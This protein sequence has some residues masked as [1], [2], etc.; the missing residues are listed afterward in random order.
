MTPAAGSATR[1][2][3]GATLGGRSVA[4]AAARVAAASL[5]TLPLITRPRL[6]AL[7]D[8]LA[9]LLAGPPTLEQLGESLDRATGERTTAQGSAVRRRAARDPVVSARAAGQDRAARAP[10]PARPDSPWRLRDE[11]ASP[12][13]TPHAVA[14][15]RARHGATRVGAKAIG[16]ASPEASFP[17]C[18]SSSALP[19]LPAAPPVRIDVAALARA[20]RAEVTSAPAPD[21]ATSPQQPEISHAVTPL[22]LVPPLTPTP[23]ST[24]TTPAGEPSASVGASTADAVTGGALNGLLSRWDA[25][26]PAAELEATAATDTPPPAAAPRT[27]SPFAPLTSRLAEHAQ[28][29]TLWD[30]PSDA[31]LA[32]EAVEVA[33]DALLRREVEQHG[34][35]GGLR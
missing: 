30:G 22:T 7:T 3:L 19:L 31:P 21:P 24:P 28:A 33:L 2:S 5:R 15:V 17:A 14:A 27:A 18:V 20:A 1:S 34:L 29:S 35:S 4:L 13:S 6:L 23:G 25:A 11:A 16:A 32:L 10:G 9:A 26:A 8:P 12:T